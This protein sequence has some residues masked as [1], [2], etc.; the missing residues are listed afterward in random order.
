MGAT[1]QALVDLGL[2]DRRPD[3]ADGRRTLVRATETGSRARE[4]AWT[5]RTRVLADRLSALPEDDRA[6]VARA[7]AIL[8]PLTDD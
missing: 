4:D 2:V 1:V 7:L 6:A 5:T 8:L 3:P